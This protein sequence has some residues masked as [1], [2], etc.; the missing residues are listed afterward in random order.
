MSSDWDKHFRAVAERWKNLG[1]IPQPSDIPKTVYHYT[2]AAGLAGMLK[3]G[4]LWATDYRFLN[5]ETE[6]LYTRDLA[7]SFI[8]KDSN[9]NRSGELRKSL[10]TY[11]SKWQGVEQPSDVF[12]FSLSEERDDLSQWRGYARDGLGFTLGFSGP[13]LLRAF[14]T[15]ARLL[16][17]EY[18][19]KTQLRTL[20][21]IFSGFTR[22]VREDC[23]LHPEEKNT[24][25]NRAAHR[26]D[27][28]CEQRAPVNKHKSFA[29]EK[30]WR[31]VS[32]IPDHRRKKRIVTRAQGQ[33]LVNYIELEPMEGERLPIV[34]I[35]VG[36][37]YRGPDQV[38]AV[39]ALCESAGYDAKVYTA[40]TPY[41][42]TQIG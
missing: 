2:D 6:V 29:S 14:R 42:R 11:V 32:H 31:F 7:R 21:R 5:D 23:K 3:N 27:W 9:N 19:P 8:C 25:L 36:P 16:K 13:N 18:D 15:R 17:M 35:G 22:R 24:I 40:D 37:G 20:A 30:E 1:Y 41:Q 12:V 38:H 10:C 4:K 34:E 33:R 26:F 39:K 28:C